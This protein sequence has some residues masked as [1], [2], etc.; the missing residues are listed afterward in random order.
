MTE[1]PHRHPLRRPAPEHHPL[2]GGKCASLGTMSQAGLPVPPG[3]AVTTDVFV[4]A[5]RPPACAADQRPHGRRR[6][7]R[8]RRPV[9][10]RRRRRASSCGAG[11]CP[12]CTRA[13]SGR[14]TPTSARS[15]GV[16]DVPVAV[17]SSA[18]AEDSPDASFAGEH[19]TYLWVCGVDEV[20]RRSGPAG[21]ASS[22]SGPS[23]TATRW[24]TTTTRSTWPSRCRRWSA[25]APPA[26]PSPWT[27]PTATAPASASTRP[28]A[29][30]RVSSPVTSP[31]TTSWSTR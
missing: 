12:R 19:D 5:Q 21:R 24:A 16:E 28:G 3:F 4:D 10:G 18:T 30:A 17:R 20:L 13:G 1:C 27:R 9:G 23:P 31:P 26:S 8:R 25:R 6:H 2:V 15:A 22:P 7:R 11:S 14:C 29:S